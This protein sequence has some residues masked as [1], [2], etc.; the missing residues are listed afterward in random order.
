MNK[1]F[2]NKKVGFVI[3]ARLGSQRLPGKALLS[4]GNSTIIGHLINKLI[5]SGIDKR[6]IYIA[7]TTSHLD[8]VLTTYIKKFGIQIVRGDEDNVLN[9]FGSCNKSG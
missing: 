7:T 9:S 6:L 2:E 8:N 4:F 3:Q 1:I 5:E